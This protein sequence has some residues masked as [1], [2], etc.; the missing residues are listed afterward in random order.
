MIGL[1]SSLFLSHDSFNNRFGLI[2]D[3]N[4]FSHTEVYDFEI[5][6]KITIFKKRDVRAV[7]STLTLIS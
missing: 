3:L 5:I 1:H 4:I 7:N 6:L 2:Q